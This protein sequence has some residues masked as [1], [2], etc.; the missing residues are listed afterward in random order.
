MNGPIQ[1]MSKMFYI[2]VIAVAATAHA[3]AQTEVPKYGVYEIILTT[4]NTYTNPYTDVSLSATFQG[5]TKTITIE[6]FWDGGNTWKIRVAPTQVGTWTLAAVISNDLQLNNQQE[7]TTFTCRLPTS[8]EISSNE[9]LRHGFIQVNPNFPRSFMYAD[10]TPFFFMGDTAWPR[11]FLNGNIFDTGEF[12][13][14]VDGR[15]AQGFNVFTNAYIA[16]LN[17]AVVGNGGNETGTSSWTGDRPVISFYQALDQ[18]LV[19][20]NS[21]GIRPMIVFG[22]PDKGT[23]TDQNVLVRL[24]RYHIARWA[25]YD[26]IWSGVKEYE[27]W[28]SNAAAAIRAVGDAIEQ[29]DPYDHPASTHTLNSTNELGNDVWLDFNSLQ[30]G[31]GLNGAPAQSG[32]A[33]VDSDYK[34]FLKP[35]V[36]TEAFYEGSSYSGPNKFNNDPQILL[37]GL[38]AIQLYGGWNAGYQLVPDSTNLDM[39]GYLSQMNNTSAVYHTYLKQFFEQTEFWKL[40]PD[41]SLVLAGT[42]WAAAQPGTEYVLFLT[43]GGSVTVDLTAVTESLPVEWYNPRTGEVITQGTTAGGAALT[44]TAPDVS[45]WA[46]HIG[47]AGATTPT[48]VANFVNGNSAALSS[49]VYLWNPS[50]SAGQVTVRVFTLPLINGIAQ[51][52]TG[53][54]LDLGILEARSALNLKLVEDILIPLGIPTPYTTD[55][56]N[57]TLEFTIQAA[58]ARG[59]AQVFS[60]NLAFGTYPLQEIPSTSSGSPTVLVANFVNGNDAALLSRVYLWNPSTSAGNLTVR[61]FTLP[62][63]DIIPQE[64]TSSPLD[65]GAL[66]AKSAVNLKLVED[67]LTPLG[68]T[69]PYTDDGGNLTLEFTIEAENVRGVAQVFSGSL[70]FGTYP[71][72]VMQ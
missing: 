48:L 25:A 4:T 14:M 46:L 55:G 44:F 64:L 7:G 31:G 72:Q 23:T 69:P 70:A 27:E 42:A 12:Q 53:T 33:L 20:M 58:D 35:V 10:G 1:S 22:A 51:E 15:A 50:T 9:L 65:L 2:F 38:W 3:A 67:I 17:A 34:N 5:T 37:E 60:S 11:A 61:V 56:G 45:S 63:K 66:G 54:P 52:L 29:Y 18:R 36:Q 49:R 59:A 39:A 6:G 30:R 41:N 19:Y 57:L 68:I 40:I 32:V 62:F 71:L 28:G 8:P 43:V 24:Q 16:A 13:Q 26:V 47:V 21:K